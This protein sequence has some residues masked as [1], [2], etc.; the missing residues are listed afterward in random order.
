MKSY[1]VLRVGFLFLCAGLG[2]VLTLAQTPPP[3][4]S[5]TTITATSTSGTG[6]ATTSTTSTSMSFSVGAPATPTVPWTGKRGGLTG[7]VVSDD[8]Q[9]FANI[10]V[11]VMSVVAER[12]A[13]RS[14]VTDDE[15]N[16]KLNDL[17]AGAYRILASAPGYVNPEGGLSS[18]TGPS[19]ATLYRVGEN[20]TI[21]LVKGG[22]ITGKALD[23]AGQPI[24]ASYVNAYRVRDSE[25][26]G[27]ADTGLIGRGLTDDRGVYRIFGLPSGS[28]VVATDGSGVTTT[29]AREVTTYYPSATRDT[30]QEVSV[31]AGAEV[32]GIDIRHRGELGHAVSGT[33]AGYVE[34]RAAFGSGVTVDLLQPGTGLRVANASVT[35]TSNGGFVMYGVP[36]G[37]YEAVA[38]QQS[39]GADASR[40]LSTPRRVVVK[41]ADVTGV[42]LRIAGLGS[43]AGR[44]VVEKLDAATSCPIKSQGGREELLLVAR[45]DEKDAR[46]GR[47]TWAEGMPNESGDFILAALM[48]GQYRLTSQLPNE[49]WYVKAMTLPSAAAK[50]PATKTAVPTA[51][52][53]ATINAA[54]GLTVKSNEKVADLTVTLAEGAA[55]L[56]GRLEGKRPASRMRVHLVPAEKEAADDLLR[57]AEVVT[58]D[59][60]FAFSHLAPGKYWLVTRAVPED[61][62][63]EKPAKP[64]AW[65][66]AARTKLRAEAEAAKLAVELAACQ[67]V[68]NFVVPEKKP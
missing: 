57:Y 36:D 23:S 15:G 29:S 58:R 31:T 41:G 19:R 53:A 27:S 61:E 4:T 38:Y 33:V 25:G 50:P 52:K 14:A 60:A 67:R 20:A 63:A 55:G 42:E 54:A 34:S 62:S 6:S 40:G 66:T 44:V 5:S 30:A 7:R 64:V 24:V 28:Y 22:V 47:F 12:S 46:A 17:P 9:P 35:S 18:N 43:I 10:G 1:T 26:R 49:H 13:R 32:Q 11:S 65:D 2:S 8:G 59:A 45:R 3:P 56:S 39:S 68:K 16:F 48:A 51:P 37:E 21:T